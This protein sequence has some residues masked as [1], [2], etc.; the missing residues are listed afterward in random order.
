VG[1]EQRLHQVSPH[2]RHHENEQHHWD[3]ESLG[4]PIEKFPRRVYCALAFGVGLG[5][6]FGFIDAATPKSTANWICHDATNKRVRNR[7]FK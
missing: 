4:N 6:G 3:A 7:V 1:V 5:L 2:P